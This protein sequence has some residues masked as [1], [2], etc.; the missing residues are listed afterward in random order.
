M[1]IILIIIA[2]QQGMDDLAGFSR[3]LDNE[4]DQSYGFMQFDEESNAGFNLKTI[5]VKAYISRDL[6]ALAPSE[7]CL[8]MATRKN[9]LIR[10]KLCPDQNYE[11]ISIPAKPR[12]EVLKLWPDLCGYHCLLIMSKG[13]HC[14]QSF[15]RD[16]MVPLPKVAGLDITAVAYPSTTTPKSTG[17][18][19]L[20]CKDG[21][22]YL[23]RIEVGSK[24]EVQEMTP[25]KVFQLPPGNTIYGL[26][27]ETYDFLKKND[28]SARKTTLVMAVTNDTCYQFTGILPFDKYFD[29]YNTPGELNK[30]K[31]TVPK[32][33]IEDSEL[34]LYYE[35]QGKAQYELHSF[36]W[37]CGAGVCYGQFR[38][39]QDIQLRV[40]VKDI[41]I[42]PYKKK[43][44]SGE[45]LPEA[46]GITEYNLYFLYVDNLTVVS[47]ITKEIEHSENFRHD[48]IMRQ[49]IY[50]PSGKSM[51]LGSIKGVHRLMITGEDKDLW[52]QQL[53][54]GNFEEALAMCEE[55]NP[56]YLGYVAGLYADS[57]FK[58]GKYKESAII[59]ARS[60]KS[61]E[62]ILLKYLM[63]GEAEGLSCTF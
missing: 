24:G 29:K 39:K 18:I 60:S 16:D 61:F 41:S 8:F 30:D 21:S 55:S 17:D 2:Q 51:W 19:L 36:A 6:V 20:G 14:Y 54:S 40:V 56:K 10:K 22:I 28:K 44:S 13:E 31:K 34:K 37:K 27:Y 63:I 32:G 48:E 15:L 3:E 9:K 4:D 45:E 53:E 12:S 52:K 47:K 33:R 26:V 59:Y 7:E 62:E 25:R 58:E 11:V 46:V 49:M 1:R 43:G 42:E 35:Y 5:D 50:D 57:K 23:Y 38:K